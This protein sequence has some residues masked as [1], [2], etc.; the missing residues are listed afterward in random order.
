MVNI[1]DLE[2]IGRINFITYEF[3]SL[4]T[5]I[6]LSSTLIRILTLQIMGGLPKQY[7]LHLKIK[8][9]FSFL[10]NFKSKDTFIF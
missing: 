4:E 10:I 7:S 6:K 3:F 5:C 9:T 1:K 8:D 2:R